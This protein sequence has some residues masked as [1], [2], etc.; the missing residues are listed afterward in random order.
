MKGK[1]KSAYQ[2]VDV[3]KNHR[4]IFCYAEKIEA[5][6]RDGQTYPHVECGA[7]FEKEGVEGD[8]DYVKRGDERRLAGLRAG[9][10]ARLLKK[11]CQRQH[12]AA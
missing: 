5:D 9:R 10:N 12:G 1:Y 7:L 4:Q 8:E 11:A 6:C 3:R 2:D